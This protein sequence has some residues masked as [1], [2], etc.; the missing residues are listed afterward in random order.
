[1]TDIVAERSA[2]FLG[3]RFKRLAERM[4]SQV[5]RLV[6]QAQLPLQPSHMPVLGTLDRDG[7]Q[8]IGDLAEAMQV[9]QPTVTRAIAR[10][11]ELGLVET[12]REHRDQRHKTIR[13]TETGRE[14][15]DRAKM[16]VWNRTEAA[17]EEVLGALDPSFLAQLD[18][19]EALLAREPLDVRAGRHVEAGLTIRTFTDELAPA[20]KSINLEW[21]N[22]MYAVEPI[23]LKVLDHPREAILDDGG[24]I[25]FAVVEGVGPVGTC[26]L[27]KTG[28]RAFELTKMGVLKS[29]RGA[30][31][32]E[33]LLHA[34]IAH[35]QD[36]GADP[37]FL[38]SNRKSA[39]AVH[40]YEKLGFMHDAG[41]MSEHGARYAR[42]DVAMLYRP[43]GG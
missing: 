22:D 35:A 12:N 43:D 38:L 23:D 42:C 6:E 18:A 5:T 30:K 3:S 32:G 16:L 37:L 8:T 27:K 41:I 29:A 10:L 19:L 2:L 40:L 33:A 26:A 20:F 24:A 4:Q 11:T 31:V 7:P 1:M 39:A 34:V 9:A 21:L 17:V 25:L 36:L 28:E 14:T 13:L 15:L